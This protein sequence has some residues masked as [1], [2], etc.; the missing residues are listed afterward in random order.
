MHNLPL[1]SRTKETGYSIGATIGEVIEVDVAE[2]GVQWVK[3]LR[4]RVM[5][6]VTRRLI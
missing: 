6:D 4:V 3:C 2:N 5:V 1:K